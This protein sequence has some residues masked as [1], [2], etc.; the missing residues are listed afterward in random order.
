MNTK[1]LV[2]TQVDLT[3]L[4][5]L[6]PTTCVS[7]HGLTGLTLCVELRGIFGESFEQHLLPQQ[8]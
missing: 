5:R 4:S 2:V 7:N 8:L 1:C 3:F 6:L